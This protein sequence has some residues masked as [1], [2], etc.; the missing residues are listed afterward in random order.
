[1]EQKWRVLI[2]PDTEE[3]L[4]KQTDLQARVGNVDHISPKTEY[5]QIALEVGEVISHRNIAQLV[6]TRELNP[7]IAAIRVKLLLT[8]A[9]FEGIQTRVKKQ[10]H[11]V[12]FRLNFD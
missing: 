4:F 2:W 6:T 3:K 7:P 12:Y 1:M 5:G 9:G 10:E 11:S 8:R